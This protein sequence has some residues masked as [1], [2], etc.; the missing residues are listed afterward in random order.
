MAA[1]PAKGKGKASPPPAGGGK[2]PAPDPGVAYKMGWVALLGRPPGTWLYEGLTIAFPEPNYELG[3]MGVKGKHNCLVVPMP[4]DLVEGIS[5][6]YPGVA[7]P[8]KGRLPELHLHHI[9]SGDN[10][11][12]WADY[13]AAHPARSLFVSADDFRRGDISLP[14]AS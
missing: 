2:S 12:I 5:A 13:R 9:Y 10:L 3:L 14:K 11:T 6:R 4:A 8:V 1:A 7:Q